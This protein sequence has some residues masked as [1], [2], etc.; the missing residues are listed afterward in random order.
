[1]R[2]VQLEAAPLPFSAAS[3][4]KW[5]VSARGRTLPFWDKEDLMVAHLGTR[6]RAF[7]TDRAVAREL[8]SYKK[9]LDQQAEEKCKDIDRQAK[10]KLKAF[11]TELKVRLS[12]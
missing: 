8:E 10:E 12:S 1:M 6:I 4:Q 3:R 11:E 9:R 5:K 7:G 2:R